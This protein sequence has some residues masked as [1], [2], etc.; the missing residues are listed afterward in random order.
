M[1]LKIFHL[2]LLFLLIVGRFPV[3]AQETISEEESY[4]GGVVCHP[5][6]YPNG[7]RDCLPLGPSAYIT[8]LA[9]IGLTFPPRPFFFQKP[10]PELAKVSY[11]Y[12][13]MADDLPPR[14]YSSLAD[15][16]AKSENALTY[17]PGFVYVSYQ[18][19]DET[20]HFFL[21]RSGHWIRGDGNRIHE[22][23]SF[24]GLLFRETPR[25][26][27]GWTFEQIPV[28]SAPGYG[29]AETG[30]QLPSWTIVQVYKTEVIND[31]A[32]NMIGPNQWV[33]GRKVAVVTPNTTPPEGVTNG[34]WIEVNLEEQTIAVYED[35]QL[36]FATMG[37]T[38]AE[39]FWTRPGLFQI[40]EKKEAETMRN[41]DPADFYYLEDVPYTMYF[42]GARAL[43]AAYWRTRF[44]YPQSHGCVN[45]SMG[46]ARWLFD[47]A[48]VGEWVYVHDPSGKTPTDPALYQGG[49]Y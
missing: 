27:F 10:D 26:S 49:A 40:S 18:S 21:T 22:F 3:Q 13:H 24:Q 38:G 44:G 19:M 11:R 37:A 41:N 5:D 39:P 4:G 45:L 6:A 48:N 16:Q 33:E 47:W 25:V 32:W 34:R 29:A 42:D 28:H 23:S 17:A 35:S 36:V 8:S 43:H 20:G 14:F 7:T 30:Q 2:A 15:A 1:R 31:T 9:A 46:D 12:F